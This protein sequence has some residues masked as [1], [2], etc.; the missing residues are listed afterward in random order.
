MAIPAF[1]QCFHR[2]KRL[3]NTC[4]TKAGGTDTLPS[5]SR[6]PSLT[7]AVLATIESQPTVSPEADRPSD[8][9]TA[10]ADAPTQMSNATRRTISDYT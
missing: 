9:L 3:G 6:L 7:V 2:P 10:A 1:V 4:G 8:A 5:T